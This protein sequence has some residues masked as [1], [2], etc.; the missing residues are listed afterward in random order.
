MKTNPT[1]RENTKVAGEATRRRTR[2]DRRSLSLLTN[3]Q[4]TG[5]T[6]TNMTMRT[7]TVNIGT[8][9]GASSGM[10]SGLSRRLSTSDHPE[11]QEVAATTT[12]TRQEVNI[13]MT[14][15]ITHLR[16]STTPP[17]RKKSN[18]LKNKRNNT[19]PTSKISRQSTRKSKVE[20]NSI[21]NTVRVISS[22]RKGEATQTEAA[23][24]MSNLKAI[25]PRLSSNLLKL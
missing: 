16:E 5:L 24:Q 23:I 13:E 7:T 1:T 15:T 12:I 21:N 14:S 17:T 2:V 3:L 18:L 20:D 25:L 6:T 11:D 10:S 4:A 9:M 19:K 22:G 8:T